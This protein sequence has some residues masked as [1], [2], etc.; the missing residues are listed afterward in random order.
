MGMMNNTDFTGKNIIVNLEING[1][2]NYVSGNNYIGHLV[3]TINNSIVTFDNI[4]EI[5]KVLGYDFV[6]CVGFTTESSI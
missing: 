1:S 4:Y 5:G 2:I 6:G 3:G